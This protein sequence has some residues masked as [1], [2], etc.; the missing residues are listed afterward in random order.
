MLNYFGNC[1]GFRAIQ[2]FINNFKDFDCLLIVLKMMK[3]IKPR[4]KQ[5]YAKE[6]SGGIKEAMLKL[7]DRVE[8]KEL[9]M[10]NKETV[11]F[12][13]GVT[14]VQFAASPIPPSHSP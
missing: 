14:E 13:F 2:A 11:T 4:F 8:E 3:S 9:K 7:S 12:L 10:L 6:F 1:G 5:S